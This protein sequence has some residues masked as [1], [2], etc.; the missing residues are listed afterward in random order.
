MDIF[1]RLNRQTRE[2]NNTNVDRF[3]QS[4]RSN[5]RYFDTDYYN[6]QT[7]KNNNGSYSNYYTKSNKYN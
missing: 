4:T 2:H 3:N 1:D 6:N 5:Y 7:Y